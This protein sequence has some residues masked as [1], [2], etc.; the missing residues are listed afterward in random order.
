MRSEIMEN[1]N[2]A[3]VGTPCQILAATKI[4]EY[5]E[6]TGGSP[7]DLK[8]GL[9]CMEN[10]SYTYLKKFLEDNNISLNDVKSF[11]IEG[12]KFKVFI[13]N[14]DK[15]NPSENDIGNDV[16]NRIINNLSKSIDQNVAD[17]IAK[18]VVT[19]KANEIG[20]NISNNIAN[21]I[22]NAT[23]N[24]KEDNEENI[25]MVPLNNTDSF[26]RK[27]CDI[28]IDYCSDISDISVG[29][30]GSPKGWS[31]VIVRTEK[32]KEILENGEKEGYF[33]TKDLI[34][35][36]KNLLEK[37]AT[38][39][40]GDNLANIEKRE[41]ISRPV[42]FNRKINNEKIEEISS[43]SQFENLE[44]DVIS[45]GACV[46]CGAC[47]YVCPTDIIKINDRKPQKFGQ[48]KEDCHACYYACPR[49]YLSEKIMAKNL[50]TKPLGDYLDIFAVK[51]KNIEG[52]D[53]GAVSSILIYLL[54]KNLVEDV[55]IVDQDKEIPWKPISKLTEDVQEVIDASGTKYSTVPIAFKA[56]K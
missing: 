37:I 20:K 47:E 3:M 56:L 17:D 38:K 6:K 18:N 12:N 49:T 43:K 39:K 52:Q 54:E 19:N 41:A 4:N 28:C 50:K 42:L 55:F 30:I 10:F 16:A 15:N 51:S 26:K 13:K 34:E 36:D 31:T 25:F 46:L 21:D 2:V 9:F 22:Y 40:K 29:S 44:K 1:K 32:A 45:E 8:I 27:N 11:R 53:G 23:D 48:C 35:K 7:I 5:N 24:S 14:K 33:E